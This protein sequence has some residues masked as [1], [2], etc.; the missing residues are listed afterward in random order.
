MGYCF[1]MENKISLFTPA[2]LI[3]NIVT[4]SI[5]FPLAL[6]KMTGTVRLRAP[7]CQTLSWQIDMSLTSNAGRVNIVL[8]R[9]RVGHTF[10]HCPTP[11]RAAS[12]S[13]VTLSVCSDSRHILLKK[14]KILVE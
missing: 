8:C 1:L 11:W 4:I 12:P 5:F 13:V 3:L 14:R 7:F 6:G 10:V 2:M 9:A